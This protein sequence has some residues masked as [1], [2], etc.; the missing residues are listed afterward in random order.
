MDEN[1]QPTIT[2]VT[3]EVTTKL[4]PI[5]FEPVEGT[6]DLPHDVKNGEIPTELQ[7]VVGNEVESTDLG[8]HDPEEE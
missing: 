1:T 7:Q 8:L 3:G 4:P 5:D 2:D 6:E